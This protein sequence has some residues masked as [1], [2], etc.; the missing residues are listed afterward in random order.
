[1]QKISLNGIWDIRID[2][3]ENGLAE[4]WAAEPIK[5]ETQLVVP[6]CVQQLD[7]YNEQFP[8]IHDKRNSFLGTYF[9]EK[10]VP[11]SK[12]QV[13]QRVRLCFQGVLPTSHLWINGV[14]VN[15]NIMGLNQVY[16][17]IT[18]YIKEG[19]NR[20]T[21][22][23][24]EQ[25][26]SLVLGMR[27][28]ETAWS[29]IFSEPYIEI[30]GAM[31]IID[32]YISFKDGVAAVCG[33]IINDGDDFAGTIDITVDKI[34]V[35]AKV[36]IKNGETQEFS[37]PVDVKGLPRWSYRNP[38]LVDVKIACAGTEKTFKTG[39]REITTTKERILINGEP[40]FFKG[41]GSEYFSPTICPVTQRELLL[42]RYNAIKAYGFNFFRCHTHVPTEEEMCIADELGVM[43]CVEFGLITNFN[44]TL[45]YDLGLD[46]WKNFI[47]QSRKHPSIVIY[48][49]GNEGSQFLVDNQ[50]YRNRAKMCYKLVKENTNNQLCI[51]TFGMQSEVP[52]IPNDFETPHLWSENFKWAYDGLTDIPWD[53]LARINKDKPCVIHEYGKFGVWPSRKEEADTTLP[54]GIKP[55]FATQAYDWLKRNGL[56]HLEDKLVK[57]S[58]KFTNRIDRTILE[59]ARRQPYVS[60][61][62]LWTFFRRTFCNAGLSDDL[63]INLNG[64]TEMFKNGCN[65]EVAILMERGFLD[66]AIPCNIEQSVG[67]TISNFSEGTTDGTLKIALTCD[68]KEI[69]STSLNCKLDAGVTEEQTKFVFNVPKEYNKKKLELK[70]E[71]TFANGE[72]RN[73]WEFWAFDTSAEDKIIYL[74]IEE[75]S[76]YR[77]IK[78]IFP[79]A[80]RLSSVDSIIIGCRSWREQ[81]LVDTASKTPETLI[82]ADVYDDVV[83]GCVENGNKVLLLDSGKLPSEWMQPNICDNLSDERDTVRFFTGFRACWWSGNLVTNIDDNNPLLG[84]FPQDGY[85]DLHFYDMVHTARSVKIKDLENVFGKPA[86]TVISCIAKI[87][88]QALPESIFQDPNAIKEQDVIKAPTFDGREQGYLLKFGDK[89]ALTT[90]K[91]SDNPAGIGLLKNLVEQMY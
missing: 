28:N 83:K 30:G 7:F 33:S 71:Y 68:G 89:V 24:T 42:Q 46:M 10:I 43:L 12:E 82:I 36:E 67:I 8:A 59:D 86:E 25:Y 14:Y 40:T 58:R 76:V 69:T 27:Y 85:C 3:E 26:T 80:Q 72:S 51:V 79:K 88:A 47:R 84:D 53:D 55:D 44:K 2:P 21:V 19:D 65:A 31:R 22:A 38:A 56:E 23:I 74:H 66:R 78:K 45:P 41:T 17:D 13:A 52:E 54:L 39:V 1:M 35:S 49:G 6:G 77:A 20:I 5:A 16:L 32:E 70:A 63:G 62:A 90:L 64:D 61:Y 29:G 73:S 60:G 81:Q 18:E 4:C 37:V 50:I 48:C 9:L 11:L 75:L 91:L 57:N 15:K 34:S 87:P